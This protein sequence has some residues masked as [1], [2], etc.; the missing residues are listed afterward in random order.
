MAK[1][2]KARDGPLAI[3]TDHRDALAKARIKHWTPDCAG[4]NGRME[5]A[6]RLCHWRLTVAL[7]Q[8]SIGVEHRLG[9]ANWAPARCRLSKAD[10]PV[11]PDPAHNCLY[12]D[13]ECV[14]MYHDD[15]LIAVGH[16]LHGRN[17]RMDRDH[18]SYEALPSCL[19]TNFAST[20][21]NHPE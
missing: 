2:L 7:F 15:S 1:L 13:T 9:C 14:I 5:S 16:R 20:N 18:L 17:A 21:P 3:I 8:A 6:R 4:H 12:I 11:S 10:V 19:N